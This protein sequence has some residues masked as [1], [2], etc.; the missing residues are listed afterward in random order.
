[1]SST[2]SSENLS[3]WEDID[4]ELSVSPGLFSEDFLRH[5]QLRRSIL[6]RSNVELSVALQMDLF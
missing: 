2:W 5:S 1:M 6:N 3:E 4:P